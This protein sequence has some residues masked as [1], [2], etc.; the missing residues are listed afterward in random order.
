MSDQEQHHIFAGIDTHAD[1]HHVAI[2]T[3]YGKRVADQEF[4][5]T[6][7]GHRTIVDF[8][9]S[10]GVPGGVGIEGTGT[11]GAALTKALRRAGIPVTEVNRPNRQQRRNQGK[12][13]PLDAYQ[14]AQSVLAGTSTA[15]PKAKDGPVECL[16]VLRAGRASAI[17]S[18]TATINQIR[19]LL[20]SAEDVVRAK[21]RGM[22]TLPMI[23][24]MARSRPTGH[25]AD[26]EYITS[27][28]LRTLAQRYQYLTVE[29]EEASTSLQKILDLYAPLLCDLPGVGT[30][31]ASQLLVTMGDNKERINNEAQFAALAGVAPVPASSGK[32]T[33]HR[34]SRGGDRQA[35]SALHHVVLVRMGSDARTK[36]YV[37][38]RTAEGKSKREIMRCLKRYVAREVYRQ[39]THPVPAPMITDLRLQRR[40]LGIT[41]QQVAEHL[42]QWPSY[43]S[44]L[45]RGRTRNDLLAVRYR[46]WLNDQASA[47]R[48]SSDRL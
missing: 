20:V 30:D 6:S 8:I 17:K 48:R 9:T 34:L 27:R 42:H 40:E 15:V 46:S 10:H 25:T 11:Y 37:D 14:A 36:D 41:L 38:K 13:D 39:I 22:P 31:V 29:I 12:S 35:N 5:A 3:G 32:S 44:R 33:R 16:R 23:A 4:V 19:D 47:E 26:P 7:S 24:M 45:E 43:L 21:Y 18:R 1:T 28:V 2:I